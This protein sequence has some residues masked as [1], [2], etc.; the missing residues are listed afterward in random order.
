MRE[1]PRAQRLNQAMNENNWE[2]LN[3]EQAIDL[4]E[5]IQYETN[6]VVAVIKE[7]YDL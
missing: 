4:I 3:Q 2:A 7:K 5:T 6:R 1:A